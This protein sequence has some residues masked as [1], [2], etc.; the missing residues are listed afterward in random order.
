MYKVRAVADINFL[1]IHIAVLIELLSSNLLI[2]F[3]VDIEEIL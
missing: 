2:I 1:S 3:V